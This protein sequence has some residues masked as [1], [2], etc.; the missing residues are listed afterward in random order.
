[1]LGR[2]TSLH[3]SSRFNQP[4]LIPVVALVLVLGDVS[5]LGGLR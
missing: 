1:M 4:L 2:R 5:P 3:G